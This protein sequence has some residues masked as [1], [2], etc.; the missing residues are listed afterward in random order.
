MHTIMIEFY[1]ASRYPQTIND[2]NWDL[3]PDSG[4]PLDKIMLRPGISPQVIS[5]GLNNLFIKG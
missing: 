3:F 2:E 5:P 4:F 1:Y